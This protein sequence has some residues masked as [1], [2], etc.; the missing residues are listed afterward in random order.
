ML[1][2]MNIDIH[3]VSESLFNGVDCH[4]GMRSWQLTSAGLISN[5]IYCEERMTSVNGKTIGILRSLS[6][7]PSSLQ[8]LWVCDLSTHKTALIS[9]KVK[10]GIT[11][12]IFSDDLYYIE[13]VSPSE[14]ILMKL[15]MLDFTIQQ[16]F[17]FENNLPSRN[18]TISRDGRYYVNGPVHIKDSV[19]G[20]SC[21]DLKKG[22]A[23]IFHEQI[24]ICNP[25]VQ[26]EP[27]KG[28]YLLIQQNRGC[29]FDINGNITRM[30]GD[31][32]ATVYALDFKSGK[33]ISLPVGKPHTSHLTGHECWISNSTDILFTSVDVYTAHNKALGGNIYRASLASKEVIPIARGF[34]FNHISCS[35]DGRFFVADDFRSGHIFIGSIKNGKHYAVCD[36]QTTIGRP[37]YAHP[38]PYMTGDNKYIVYNSTK[39]GIAQVYVTEIPDGLLDTLED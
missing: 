36:P 10:Y 14:N 3:W 18:C 32:G 15:N 17:D 30:T 20:L 29:E 33:Q 13:A 28:E 9:E 8:Q 5:N 24:D 39:T 6:P 2:K 27:A 25:H 16:V 26:F 34:A 23:D 21:I 38:H 12:N 19:F 31:M 22:T 7:D 1:T 35:A 4:F 11:S 37:Q